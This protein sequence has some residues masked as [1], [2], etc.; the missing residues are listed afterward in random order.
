[1]VSE[2]LVTNKEEL[3]AKGWDALDIILITGDAYVDH[4]SFAASLLGRWLEKHGFKVGIIAQPSWTNTADFSELGAPRLFFGVTAGNL[5][6]LVAN[7]TSEKKTR[8]EDMY[9]PGGIVGKRPDRAV[10]VYCNIL[11]QLYKDSMI[12]IGGIEASL[13][14]ITHYDYWS[15]KVRRPI[16]FDCRADVLVYGMGELALL[17]LAKRVSENKD[18]HDVGNVSYISKEVPEED[19]LT[20]DSF[21]DVSSKEESFVSS[22]INYHKEFVSGGNRKV[23]QECQKRY[24]IINPPREFTT[25]DLDDIAELKFLRKQHPSYKEK[26]P[27]FGFVRDSVVTHRGCYGGCYFCVLGIHQGKKIISRSEESLVKEVKNIISKDSEFKGTIQDVGGPTANMYESVCS[28]E[29]PCSRFS[30]LM[31]SPCKYLRPNQQSHLKLIKEISKVE[32]VNN[33]FVNSG[34]RFDLALL[35]KQ[36]SKSILANHVSGQLSMAPEHIC[37]NVLKLMNKPNNS[38]YEEFE[39]LFEQENKRNNKKQFII[40]YFIA[41]YPGSSLNDMYKLSKYLRERNMRIKQVQNFIPIPMS[42]ASVMYYTG[43]DPF[44]GSE[45]YVA[46]GDDRLLQRALLQP[47]LKSNFSF[48]KRALNK[49]GKENDYS[50]LTGDKQLKNNSG[51]SWK[52]R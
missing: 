49:I 37:D 12:V 14:R 1:M 51:P 35:D 21:E 23:V 44:S 39:E 50:Y 15:N 31:P 8:R 30:C 19:V 27:A 32:G 48:V 6:S 9:S 28:K 47:W 10:T 3:K 5:D 42:V 22:H 45:L 4:Q 2:F 17:E 52:K 25:H 33:V 38:V 40:P 20:I 26:V 18:W 29:Q 46:K 41:A 34:I 36:Y 7:N 11:K 24:V 43:K 13:R 16:L